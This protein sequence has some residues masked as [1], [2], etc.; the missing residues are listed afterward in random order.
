MKHLAFSGKYAEDIIK[1]RKRATIRKKINVRPGDL[2]LVHSG[3]KIIGT[4]KI[5]A[6]EKRRTE[7]LTEDDAK[8]DGFDSRDEMMKEI[9]RLGYEGEVYIIKFDFK[10]MNS[11]SI[12]SQLRRDG[13]QRDCNKR[14]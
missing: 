6:V 4:A 5:T 12:F 14:T 11:L 7:D 8:L 9:E 10:P 13:S 1:G 3:G 2:V